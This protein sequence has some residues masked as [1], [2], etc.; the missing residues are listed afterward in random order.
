[1]EKLHARMAVVGAVIA[2][3]GLPLPWI[4]IGVGPEEATARGTDLLAALVP[5]VV[6]A[7]A[8]LAFAAAW[9]SLGRVPYSSYASFAA[10]GLCLYLL[11]LL[12][13]AESAS[14]VIPTS[15]LPATLQRSSGVIAAGAGLWVSLLGAALALLA[16]SPAGSW[17]TRLHS[18]D[19]DRSRMRLAAMALLFL[20]TV[21]VGWLRYQAWIGTSLLGESLDLTGQAAPWIG[22]A[23][24]FAVFLLFAAL[25]LAVLSYFEIAGL[26]AAASGWLI[27]F[28]AACAAIMAEFL[29]RLRVGYLVDSLAGHS[30]TFHASIAVWATYLSGLLIAGVGALLVWWQHHWGEE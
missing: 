12:V 20:L 27:S 16:A 29:A 25:L 30:V 4:S 28:S 18:W 17:L 1:V 21:L 11:L 13:T 19:S 22:P 10:G 6:A 2:L 15:F 7:L 3:C 26:L 9:W 24:L 14:G 5:T 23:S 8:M